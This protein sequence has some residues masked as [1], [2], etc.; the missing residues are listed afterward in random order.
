MEAVTRADLPIWRLSRSFSVKLIA[1]ALI[2]LTIPLFIYW[3]FEQAEQAQAK[4]LRNS[5]AQIGRVIAAMLRPRFLEFKHESPQALSDALAGAAVGSTKLKVLVR[6]ANSGPDGFI[7]VAA[8]PALPA[9]L[10]TDERQDLLRSGVFQRLAPTCDGGSDLAI[11]L[12]RAKG[13]PEIL[14]SITPVHVPDSCWIVITSQSA[15]DL[16]SVPIDR[17]FW[18]TPTMRFAATIYIVCTALIVA[19]FVQMWRNVELFRKAA[20]NIRLRGT[21]ATSFVQLNTIPELGR[22]AADFDSLVATLVASQDAIRKTAED[23]AHALKAPL[24]VI[25]QS[26]E[27]LKRAIGPAS[28]GAARAVQLIESSVAR[29][30][31]LV[32]SARDLEQAGADAVFPQHS[33]INLSNFLK[34]LVAGHEAALSLQGKH[35]SAQ[36]EENIMAYANEELV[37]TVVENLLDNAASYTAKGESIEVGLARDGHAARLTVSDHGPGVDPQLISRIFDRY[38]SNRP[39]PEHTPDDGVPPENHQGLGLWIVKRNIE[40]LGGQVSGRNRD[41][42][43][44]EVIVSLRSVV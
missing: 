41:G 7:Y 8:Y 31:S 3:Q 13:A 27:P 40:G 37:E 15:A 2:L 6:P 16:S 12:D 38:V 28:A 44:F 39:Q 5:A 22:V 29:L 17:S 36:I 21:G 35:L 1:L 43:G 19:L 30:D 10:L 4:L 24:A 9:N 42:G 11:R 32:T 14:T 34:R 33:E 20:R 26:V 18:S 25:A 23:T